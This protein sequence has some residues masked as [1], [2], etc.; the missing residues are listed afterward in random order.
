[1][2]HKPDSLTAHPPFSNLLLCVP[3]LAFYGLSTNMGLYLKK[4]LGYPAD[5]ASQ[6]LQVWKATVSACAV[7]ED[8][9]WC[10]PFNPSFQ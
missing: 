1:M 3:R 6:L 7:G 4:V 10:N 5:Q 2:P 9:T 8:C